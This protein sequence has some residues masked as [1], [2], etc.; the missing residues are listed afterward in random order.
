MNS[1]PEAIQ[2]LGE[3][4][5]RR[6]VKYLRYVVAT[7]V[8]VVVAFFPVFSANHFYQNFVIL[9]LVG[10]IG[11]TGLNIISGYAGYTSLGHGAFLGIGTYAAAILTQHV[12][13][14]PFVWMPVSGIVASACAALL[15]VVA[16]RAKGAAFA[17]I[18]LS[19]GAIVLLLA[20]NWTSVTHGN[21]GLYFPLPHSSI[22]F[23]NWPFHF[24][25]VGTLAAA[26]L[27]SWFVG[28]TRF[29]LGLMSIREDESK[30]ETVG[31]NTRAYKLIG[32]VISA[33]FIGVAGAVYG[34]YISSVNPVAAFSILVSVQFVIAMLLGGAGTLW[35]PVFGAFLVEFVNEYANNNFGGGG[36]ARLAMFGGLLVLVVL[37]LPQGILVSA[38]SVFSRWV[39]KGRP[40]EVGS[41]LEPIGTVPSF[42]STSAA[43]EPRAGTS[44]SP[45]SSPILEVR[46]I[47]KRFGG[48][49]VLSGCDITVPRGSVTGLIGPNGSGKTTLFNIVDGSM[50]CNGG[51]VLLNGSTVTRS[52]PWVRSHMGLSR[53]FQITR[54]F[55]NLTVL[56][57]MLAPAG[58]TTLGSLVARADSGREVDRARDL[59]DFVGLGRYA[60]VRAGSLSYGQQRLV[61]LAQVLMMRP[62]LILLDEPCAGINPTLIERMK[63][64]IRSLNQEGISFLI[65][66][67]NM[68]FVMSLCDK[69]VVLANGKRLAEGNPSDV[70]NN[71]LV[72]DAYLGHDFDQITPAG[73][74]R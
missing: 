44:P 66:E 19:L 32:F 28:H 30:A 70:Q 58:K 37:F 42:V 61:E 1:S 31:I 62:E 74:P 67:H 6:A 9:A 23:Q 55:Q 49:R 50:A 41:R 63:L 8:I 60:T 64:M 47:E 17:I 29:G 43:D 35:G 45:A 68:P 3:Q 4:H 34:Y 71:R 36:N 57:N 52:Q 5:R 2:S 14:S 33:F 72:L 51:E 27:T 38:S 53:T 73:E 11:A 26:L 18:S 40:A 56:E 46:G 48:L 25:L 24:A 69:V 54:L 39:G 10:A 15:G 59:L 12:H 65:V 13:V 20:Q 21:G 22:Q 16:M 7:L